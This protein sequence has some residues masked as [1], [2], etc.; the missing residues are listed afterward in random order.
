MIDDEIDGARTIAAAPLAVRAVVSEANQSYRTRNL[1]TVRAQL[2]DRSAR[3][4]RYRTGSDPVM[5]SFINRSALLFLREWAMI[6]PDNYQNI[7]VT[8]ERGALVASAK[9]GVGFLHG[10]ELWWREA[11]A[12]GRGRRYVSEIYE[13]SP[14]L[15]LLDIAV[16]VMDSAGKRAIGVVKLELRKDNLMKVI[17]PRRRADGGEQLRGDSG[18]AP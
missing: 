6:R 12:E 5:P 13:Q 4:E 3:W 7:L 15:F 8:D 16:P 11:F 17:S 9:P 2:L 18:A 10:D 14:G 1:Q